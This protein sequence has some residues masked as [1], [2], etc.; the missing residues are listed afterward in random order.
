VIQ[1]PTRTHAHIPRSLSYL[2]LMETQ[3]GPKFG[4]NRPHRHLL[5]SL[6]AELTAPVFETPYLFAL[7]LCSDILLP[8]PSIAVKRGFNGLYR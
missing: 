2:K 6:F 4:T 1:I 8:G 7:L 5:S 3:T